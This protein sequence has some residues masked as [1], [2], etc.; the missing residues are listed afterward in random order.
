MLDGI[1]VIHFTTNGT[2]M[3]EDRFG[4][5]QYSSKETSTSIILVPPPAEVEMRAIALAAVAGG[6]LLALIIPIL[7][8]EG[9][10]RRKTK[11]QME[12]L[13]VLDVSLF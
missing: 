6:L 8:R 11:E 13:K 4:P 9:F 12:A 1:D 10:F 2:A 5:K 7:I 3:I